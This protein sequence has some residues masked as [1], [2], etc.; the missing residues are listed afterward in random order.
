MSI[1]HPFANQLTPRP[2]NPRTLLL[3]ERTSKETTIIWTDYQQAY[4][5]TIL[6]THLHTYVIRPPCDQSQV[7][8]QRVERLVGRVGRF[9]KHNRKI[10]T[11]YD[12]GQN[13]IEGSPLFYYFQFYWLF[14]FDLGSDGIVGNRKWYRC[15]HYCCSC[16]FENIVLYVYMYGC[17]CVHSFWP[18]SFM[19]CALELQ[20]LLLLYFYCFNCRMGC[21]C[22]P[23]ITTSLMNHC[24]DYGNYYDCFYQMM[25]KKCNDLMTFT[26]MFDPFTSP[27]PRRV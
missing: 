3:V 9:L 22:T 6:P 7:C 23:A 17:M 26:I 13:N 21:T 24:Q 10:K 27:L 8:Y 14:Y 1:F 19:I 20:Q 4:N 11:I 12:G 5:T 18:L 16:Y 2:S 15:C 25:W